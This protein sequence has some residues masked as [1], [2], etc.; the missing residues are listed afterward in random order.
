MDLL[1]PSSHSFLSPIHSQLSLLTSS[2]QLISH[3]LHHSEIYQRSSTETLATRLLIGEGLVASFDETHKRQRKALA[4]S[5]NTEQLR[6]CLKVFQ[7]CSIKMCEK[8]SQELDVEYEKVDMLKFLGRGT[9]DI[10]GLAGFDYDF[11][12]LDQ[13]ENGKAVRESFGDAMGSWVSLSSFQLIVGVSLFPLYSLP[14]P[15]FF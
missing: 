8:V 9:L 7:K 3:I 15:S 5:F 10:I 13:G 12:A 14:L 4:P 11:Q 2:P 6:E 1:T